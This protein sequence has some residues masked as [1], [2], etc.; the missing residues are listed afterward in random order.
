[1]PLI[2]AQPSE[3]GLGLGVQRRRRAGRIGRRTGGQVFTLALI[4]PAVLYFLIWVFL[5]GGYGLYLSMT[6]ASLISSPQFVGLQNYQQ[7]LHSDEWW[8][9]LWR[10]FEYA[11]EVVVPTLL[12]SLVMAR[13]VTR[14]RRG[15]AVL[16]TIYF[17]PYVV[18]GVV[19]ALVFELIFQRY[20]LVNSA[21]HLSLAWLTNP[22]IA[23]YA[24]SIATIWSMIGYY[25]IILMAGYQQIPG[26][27]IEAA[28]IDGARMLQLIRYVELPAL[29]PTLLF[30]TISSTAAVMT[31]FGTPY[32]MTDGG[33][34]NATLTLPLLIYNEAFKYSSAGLGEAMAM[35]LLLISL[36]LALFQVRVL[37]KGR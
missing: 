4:L 26:E 16:M 37:F 13:L 3:T 9:T 18:P 1:M 36:L 33:P 21:L 25:V 14:C 29:R 7:L 27:L 12:I 10:T 31:N 11:A 8:Q 2:G 34:S 32:V 19:A 6:D 17:L 23:M 15:R 5:P 24:I 20:G 28:A 35:V 22:S 30:C